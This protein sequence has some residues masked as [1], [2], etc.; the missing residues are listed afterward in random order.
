MDRPHLRSQ[1]DQAI[2]ATLEVVRAGAL[3]SGDRLPPERELAATIGISRPALRE[4]I[5]R[6]VA[7]GVLESRHGSG[8]FVAPVDVA[9]ITEVRLLVEPHAAAQAARRRTPEAVMELRHLVERMS[10]T[11]DEPAAFAQA[12]ADLHHRIAGLT[13][14]STL[15]GILDRLSRLAQLSR[16]LTSQ[17]RD[18]RFTAL[19][20]MTELVGAVAAGD[21]EVAGTTM[22]RHLRRVASAMSSVPP[23]SV[24]AVAP[25]V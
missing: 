7:E 15:A 6:L 12:D 13:E 18:V 25:L 21:A 22:H 16:T 11:V 3:R 23:G 9:A 19:T 20:D 24:R 1:V 8:T 5:H 14:N 10:E 17:S 4:A 2:D